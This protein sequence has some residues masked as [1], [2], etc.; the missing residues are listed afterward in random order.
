[1]IEWQSITNAVS[2]AGSERRTAAGIGKRKWSDIKVDVKRSVA[3]QGQSVTATGG[4]PGKPESSPQ[5]E[6]EGDHTS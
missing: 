6:E 5:E 1:M 2:A 4:G 3:A